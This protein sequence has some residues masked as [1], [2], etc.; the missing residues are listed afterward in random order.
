[1]ANYQNSYRDTLQEPDDIDATLEDGTD[2][3][4]PP[5]EPALSPQE[6]TFKQRYDSL[7]THYDATVTS[8]RKRIADLERQLSQ[9]RSNAIPLPKSPEEIEKWRAEFPDVY[10]FVKSIARLEATE[11]RKDID[12]KL[13]QIGTI[14]KQSARDKAEAVL[15]R[16]HPD[17]DA[18]VADQ[19]FHDWVKMQPSQIQAWLYEN[20]DDPLLAAKAVDLYKSEVG[21]RKPVTNKRQ[22][23]LDAS[24]AVTKT[25]QNPVD[26]DV[27]GK[28]VWKLSEVAKLTP[29]QF[30]KLEAEIDL[31][32]DEG[33][34]QMDA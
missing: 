5:Q 12:A 32:R 26:R 19:K 21:I 7:K 20:D 3:A 14:A 29:R 6:N 34:I 8:D 2:P 11:D 33:R 10:A 9:T 22:D 27:N 18:L 31:A 24:R 4:T 1:M 28:K 25:T 16:Y 15:R 13:L 17:F 30:E 23:A